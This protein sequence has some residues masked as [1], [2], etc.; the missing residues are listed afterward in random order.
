M[1]SCSMSSD[2]VRTGIVFDR[3]LLD[4]LDARKQ[5]LDR[6]SVE[7]VSRSEVVR[8]SADLGLVATELIDDHPELRHLPTE[9]RRGLVRQAVQN[10]LDE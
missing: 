4:R 9:D 7:S 6:R 8:K 3:E 5:E 1:H 2:P 10:F